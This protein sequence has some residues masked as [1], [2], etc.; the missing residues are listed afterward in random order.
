MLSEIFSNNIS[1]IIFETTTFV[2]YI[3]NEYIFSINNILGI[4]IKESFNKFYELLNS[5][6]LK[7]KNNGR[8]DYGE[9]IIKIIIK[10]K[11]KIISMLNDLN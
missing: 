6:Y 1:R 3:N 9:K 5:G 8:L 7:I 2:N 11:I 4:S 10:N